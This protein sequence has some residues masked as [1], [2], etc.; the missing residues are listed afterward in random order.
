MVSQ[1]TLSQQL[2]VVACF[3]G[4]TREWWQSSHLTLGKK[5]DNQI[6]LNVNLFLHQ[7]KRKGGKAFK[8]KKK[9]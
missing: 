5:V 1:A 7:D 9:P 6:F 3:T 4:Q 8:N 2:L